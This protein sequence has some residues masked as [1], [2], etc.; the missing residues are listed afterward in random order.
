[1]PPASRRDATDCIPSRPCPC[2]NRQE[3]PQLTAFAAEWWGPP[4]GTWG[5][6]MGGEGKGSG[7]GTP[8]PAAHLPLLFPICGTP[9]R[10]TRQR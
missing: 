5:G 3:I 7:N 4:E 10:E 8:Q 9:F 6:E 2:R 1:M